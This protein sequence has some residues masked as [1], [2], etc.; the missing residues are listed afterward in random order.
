[1]NERTLAK[2]E[3]DKILGQLADRC[4]SAM[5][6]ERAEQLRPST[7]LWQVQEGL[8]ETTE[9]KE[10][11]RLQ[12]NVPLSGIFDIRSSVRQAA[13][14]G[15]VEP[16]ALLQIASTLRTSRQLRTFLL[17]DGEK[18]G[19]LAALAE[20]LGVYRE[21]EKAV[22]QCIGPDGE[23]LDDAS[24]ELYR[25]R[26]LMRTIQSRVREK[27]D[28]IVRNS[29]TQK[30]LQDALVT[31]R[32]DRY[33]VPVRSEYRQHIPGIIHDQSASGAT[34]FIEPMAVVELNNEWKRHEA[35]E[36]T[37]VMRILQQLSAQVAQQGDDILVSLDVLSRLDFIFAKGKLSAA[38]DGGEPAINRQGR[39]YIRL[40]RHPLIKGKV[41][42]ITVELGGDF[43][44]MVITGPNTGGKTVTLKTVGLLT[45][46]AQAGLHVPAE[47]GTEMAIFERVFVDIGDEQSI[48]QSLSTF[49]SHM[50]NIVTILQEVAPSS[51]VLLDEL[52]A[53]TDP[54]EG[55]GL[56][57]AIMEY[58]QQ[59]GAKTIATT[60]YSE[61]KAF[62]Y[63]HERVEN[64]SVEFDVETL[65][66][67]YRLLIGRPG[68]SNAFEIA[69]RLGLGRPIIE[70]ARALQSQEDRDIATMIE[71][72][73]T[74]QAQAEQ[75]RESAERLHEE[76][77]QLRR[78]LEAREKA[79]REKESA[80]LAKAREE[81]YSLVRAA[82]EEA[83]TI[84]R[85]LKEA[86]A[87]A[88]S[89][90]VLAKAENERN[91]LRRRQSEIGGER[92]QSTVP[93]AGL[94]SVR[95]GQTVFV[96]RLN[97]KGTVQ[98]LP[99]AQGELQI[100][101]GILKLTVRLQELQAA[102]EDKKRTGQTEYAAM[103]SNKARDMSRE[104]D[105][106][107]TTVDE[108]LELVAKYLDDAYLAGISPVYLIH[109]K[110]TGVLR[111]AIRNY[112]Q[113][114]AY[115]KHF[116]NGDASE[117]GLGVTVVEI[118]N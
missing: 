13:I 42:P 58:L 12:P 57:Q 78:T 85:S 3:F 56:A 71:Q 25:L 74:T 18:E 43:D 30:Y 99:N 4:V 24:P 98:T 6:R 83:E 35:A 107:G 109:G 9:A 84:V 19:L 26:R 89:R 114:H 86:L 15:I 113:K 118:K 70:R 69:Q 51:L 117:G 11:L 88:P 92:L 76:A 82:K 87:Q 75:E 116:R 105:F 64:A 101:A 39:M 27:L 77:E 68:R 112:L 49:S 67:T 14:G 90:D 103:A 53:G 41:V 106:R 20:S 55:A 65:S 28:A 52:G 38:Y 111:T 110:G 44:T 54:V 46:M 34:V 93:E 61:L 2:L 7:R 80:L 59:R 81:A 32:G 73:D 10:I 91:R 72:L 100:Q 37:E 97:Q 36:R 115:V 31:Q 96:P 33:V 104:L 16:T 108:G 66:P 5:G 23:V 50:T 1:M 21:I 47:H 63:A 94:S 60:H 40:G 48:E 8:A 22:E 29:D 17:G 45:L 62:A 79:L 95:I 102:K